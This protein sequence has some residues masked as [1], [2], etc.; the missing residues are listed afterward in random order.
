[1]RLR[2][3]GYLVLGFAL[4]GCNQFGAT[5]PAEQASGGVAIV[6][7]FLDTN[8]ALAPYQT[9]NDYE[10]NG[11]RYEPEENF[12]YTATGV[13]SY[14]SS[15]LDGALT[16][17]GEA[18]SSNLMTAAHK[19]LPFQTIV[20][21][22]RTS[23]GGSVFVRINDRGPFVSNRVIDL[24]EAAA[25][26]LN[27]LDEGIAEVRVEVME[28]ETKIF[29]AA[30]ENN[31]RIP[32]AE[33]SGT[34]EETSATQ[35]TPSTPTTTPLQPTTESAGGGFYVLV[36]TYNS[37]E[38]A[39]AIRDRMSALGTASVEEASGA[40]KVYIG[41]LSSRLDAQAMLGR[42]FAQGATNASV[43]QR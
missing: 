4:A 25:S 14:Y 18:Y 31:R 35:S 23:T 22:T 2:V 30:L 26:Q 9:G 21:V 24:S 29:R 1:M 42:V 8:A 7:Q 20:R 10:V 39:N 40:Y 12:S 32:F 36:G 15:A 43:V 16:A 13:A 28:N 41:P 17:S 33:T 19:T 11:Q 5:P 27:M 37:A 34:S 6:E 3:F 38:D